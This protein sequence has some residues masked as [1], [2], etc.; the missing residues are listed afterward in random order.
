MKQGNPQQIQTPLGKFESIAAAARAHNVSSA[1]INR[2]I[3]LHK[4]GY[5]YMNRDNPYPLPQ[6]K[7][8]PGKW[9]R[10]QITFNGKVYNSLKD[11][12]AD[13]NMSTQT[14]RKRLRNIS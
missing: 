12:A 3:R 5:V 14:L 13:N 2:S 9:I 1:S 6:P 8:L 4:Q 7:T 10:K 11:A